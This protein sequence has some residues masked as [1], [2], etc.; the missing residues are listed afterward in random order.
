MVYMLT[1]FAVVDLRFNVLLTMHVG[2]YFQKSMIWPT[3]PQ[4][5]ASFVDSKL[6]LI[7]NHALLVSSKGFKIW[8]ACSQ[9]FVVVDLRFNVLLTM[10]VAGHFQKSMIWP[11]RPQKF[12]SFVDSKL[13]LITNHALLVSSKG[14]KIWSACSQ[15]FVVV[16]LRFNVLLTMHVGG[17]FQKSMIWP[18]RPQKFASFVDSKLNLITNHALL[19][20]SKGF[21]IWSACSQKFVVVDLRFNVLLTMH[22]A[23]H[24]QKSMIW[25]TRPQ[26]FASFVDSKLNLIT[27]HA[28]LVSSKGFKIWSAC[29]QKFVVVVDLRFNVILTIHI[30]GHF[31]KSKTW[32]TCPQ[33][34]A[35]F[36]DLK[37]DLIASHALLVSSK[38]FK[39]WPTCSQNFVIVVDLRFNVKLPQ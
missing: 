19:V 38:G 29:S 10:H 34:F 1:E 39:I 14:F 7:T 30:A 20:S 3:R 9:K 28:L 26:K 36:V 11:T 27:N 24:F 33:K 5:F 37:F 16:D 12:A 2:G 18:T 32:P 23:G 6:N 4:K 13:N 31:Q 35:D 22:V 25:P 8:S 15:K 17:Y 21:K